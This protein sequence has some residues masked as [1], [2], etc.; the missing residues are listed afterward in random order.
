[1]ACGEGVFGRWVTNPQDK[2]SPSLAASP[3]GLPS[4]GTLVADPATGRLWF[5]LVPAIPATRIA[6]RF[7]EWRD[8]RRLALG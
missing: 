1:M 6:F 8:T 5:Q 7:P 4:G 3:Q 2:H